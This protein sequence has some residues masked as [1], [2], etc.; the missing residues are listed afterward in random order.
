MQDAGVED[1]AD[2]IYVGDSEVGVY[3]GLSA[4]VD[5][6]GVLWGFRD[7]AELA[8]AGAPILCETNDELYNT[9]VTR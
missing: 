3:T 1:K 8:G 4:G 6:V 2:V 7:K 5:T 9:I